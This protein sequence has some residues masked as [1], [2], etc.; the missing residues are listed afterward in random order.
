MKISV[1][2]DVKPCNLI[3]NYQTV[4]RPTGLTPR[5]MWDPRLKTP[6]L[7]NNLLPLY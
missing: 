7:G 3:T 6:D 1:F 2:L 4:V 5:K